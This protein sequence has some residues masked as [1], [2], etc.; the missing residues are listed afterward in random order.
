M[1]RRLLT[2]RDFLAWERANVDFLHDV[3]EENQKRVDHEVLSMLQRMMDSRVTKEQAGDMVL[4]T[5]LGTREGIVFT[6]EGITQ[7]LLS[8]GWVPP[9]KR[10]AGATE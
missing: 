1:S 6:R 5:M 9:S 10:K 8:I 4:K 7:T 3:L 2:A